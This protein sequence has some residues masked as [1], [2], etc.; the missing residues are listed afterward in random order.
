MGIHVSP[1]T[2]KPGFRTGR[3][4]V[5][6]FVDVTGADVISE[7]AFRLKCKLGEKFLSFSRGKLPLK[8]LRSVRGAFVLMKL[9]KE[10]S[11]ALLSADI[12]RGG[13]TFRLCKLPTRLSCKAN[14]PEHGKR[15]VR[16][17]SAEH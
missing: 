5:T 10:E 7:S 15:R 4:G 17:Q 2:S 12:R 16:Y 9:K 3:A 1:I 6:E 8:Q 13:R 14:R 11:A